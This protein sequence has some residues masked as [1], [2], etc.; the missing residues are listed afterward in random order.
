MR[1]EASG[2]EARVVHILQCAGPAGLTIDDISRRYDEGVRHDGNGTCLRDVLRRCG[3]GS[4]RE[5]VCNVDG[6]VGKG[7][8]PDIRYVVR[9]MQGSETPSHANGGVEGSN[10]L[11]TETY[12]F[13][14]VKHVQAAAVL[15]SLLPHALCMFREQEGTAL[16][17]PE[18]QAATF[19]PDEPSREQ[20]FRRIQ[21]GTQLPLSP[22]FATAALA[23]HNVSCRVVSAYHGTHLFVPAHV[24]DKALSVLLEATH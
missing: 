19:L 13:A 15:P 8:G 11:D 18:A 23:Q 12:V 10:L 22:S 14:S 17:L 6:V 16:I 2:A 20:P 9:A 1:R 4:V 21:L 3:Y 5:L 24:A 7:S